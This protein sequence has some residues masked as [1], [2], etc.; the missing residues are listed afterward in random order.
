MVERMALEIEQ[1]DHWTYT[2]LCTKFQPC[3]FNGCLEN[4]EKVLPFISGCLSWKI[5]QQ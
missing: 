5:S 3:M 4:E 2:Y 1:D